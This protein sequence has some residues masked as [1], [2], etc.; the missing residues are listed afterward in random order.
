MLTWVSWTKTTTLFPVTSH[1]LWSCCP[2]EWPA[3]HVCGEGCQSDSPVSGC[4][5]QGLRGLAPH[6]MTS[7]SACW[8]SSD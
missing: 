4:Q 3:G 7:L 1:A 5:R 6:H 2:P 8:A